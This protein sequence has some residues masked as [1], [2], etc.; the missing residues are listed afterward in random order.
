MKK[1]KDYYKACMNMTVTD[2]RGTEPMLKVRF[3][4]DVRH[5]KTNLKVFVGVTPK[6]G[7]AHVAAPFLLMV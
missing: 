7:W 5:E 3:P 2:E 4:S 6:E 1:A